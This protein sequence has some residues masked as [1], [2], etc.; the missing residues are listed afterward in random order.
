MYN[1]TAGMS[2]IDNWGAPT[3]H[4]SRGRSCS[5]FALQ[6]R[7]SFLSAYGAQLGRSI[8]VSSRNSLQVR[9]L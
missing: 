2:R 7:Q 9:S 5:N 4:Y 1:A 8:S 3:L 6:S